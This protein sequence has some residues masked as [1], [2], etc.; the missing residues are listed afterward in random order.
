MDRQSGQNGEGGPVTVGVWDERTTFR[1][2]PAVRLCNGLVEAVIVPDIGGRVMAFNLGERAFL[3]VNPAL[4]GKLFS[5]EENM[6]DGML[7]AWKNYGG[8]K[9]WPAPQGWDTDEEWHGPPDP[10]LDTGRYHLEAVE[11]SA[12]AVSARVTSPDDPRTGVRITR[13]LTIRLGSARALLHLEM[14]NVSPIPR[15]WSLWDVVQLDAT[16]RTEAGATHN[17]QTWVYIP[18]N[19]QSAF[20]NGYRVMFG[21]QENPEW[22]RLGELVAA[23]YRYQVGK[24]GVDS[25]AGWVAFADQ[26]G[27]CVFCQRFSVFPDEVYPDGGA[28]VECWTTGLGV[29]VSGLDYARDPLY[30]VEA[31]V[32]GPLRLMQPGER[33]AFE[34]EWCAARCPGPVVAVGEAGCCHQRLRVQTGPGGLRL[35]G[36]YGVF[37]PGTARL[38]WRGGQ[39]MILAE[40]TIASVS[41]LEALRLD[42]LCRSPEGWQSVE[43]V[44]VNTAGVPVGALDRADRND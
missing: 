13:Q 6:G 28:T 25:P 36:V 7:A 14:E 42:A 3:W 32:L 4:E 21:A 11:R 26:A 30:H 18:A 44:I 9:T 31:E 8:S 24:I 37:E 23:Q 33:Q 10:V 12:G 19:P 15:R 22:Q 5:A 43:L 17:D 29:S 2:W 27:G 41:P 40:E 35:T 1:G 34:I 16:R 39:E 20:P 38:V